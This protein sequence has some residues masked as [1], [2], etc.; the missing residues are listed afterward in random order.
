MSMNTLRWGITQSRKLSSLLEIYRL[1]PND[2]TDDEWLKEGNYYSYKNL[3]EDSGDLQIE[4]VPA[5]NFNGTNT[6][7]SV[8]SGHGL[9]NANFT[10]EC[11]ILPYTWDTDEAAITIAQSRADTSNGFSF[12][13]LA[14]DDDSD[15]LSWTWGATAS[16]VWKTGLLPPLGVWSH[17][18]ITRD[19]SSRKV[20]FNGKLFNSTADEGEVPT[21][22]VAFNL[23]KDTISSRYFFNGRIADV[24]VWNTTRT[25]QQIRDNMYETLTGSETGLLS[26]WKMTEGTGSTLTDDAGSNDMTIY[27]GNWTDPYYG[28]LCIE[29]PNRISNALDLDDIKSVSTSKID[30]DI[31]N[32]VDFKSCLNFDGTDDKINLPTDAYNFAGDSSFTVEAWVNLDKLGAVQTVMA[33]DLYTSNKRCWRAQFE[34]TGKLRM[35]TFQ[36]GTISPVTE[37]TSTTSIPV[38]TWVHCAWVKDSTTAKLYINGQLDKSGTIGNIYSTSGVK[39]TIGALDGPAQ[40]VDGKIDEVRIWNDVRT[41]TEIEDNMFTELTGSESGLVGYWKFNEDTGSTAEDSSGEHD[42]QSGKVDKSIYISRKG[43]AVSGTAA[44]DNLANYTMMGWVKANTY[45]SNQNIFNKWNTSENKRSVRLFISAQNQ[46]TLQVST[47]GTYESDNKIDISE[48]MENTWVHVAV[49]FDGTNHKVYIN[50][51]YEDQLTSSKYTS[52]DPFYIGVYHGGLVRELFDGELDEIMLFKRAL[53]AQEIEDIY[54]AQNAGG[55][56]G[57]MDDT[58]LLAFLHFED[59]ITDSSPEENATAFVSPTGT[60]SGATWDVGPKVEAKVLTAVTDDGDDPPTE[61]VLEFD[62]SSVDCGNDSSL[63]LTGNLTVS[64]W[65]KPFYIENYPTILQ[66]ADGYSEGYSLY[67]KDEVGKM[68]GAS[69]NDSG[70]YY[71]AQFGN[72]TPN[73]WV[74]VAWTWDGSEIR[75]YVDGQPATINFTNTYSVAHA[76]DGVKL[77]TGDLA[78]A[79]YYGQMR[80]VRVYGRQLS[81]SEIEDLYDGTAVSSTNLVG[82]WM[83]DEGTGTTITDSSSEGNDGTAT[84]TNWVTTTEFSFTEATKNS[85]IPEISESEDLTGKYLWVKKTLLTTTNTTP[86]IS[87]IETEIKGG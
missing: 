35:A 32:N 46:L 47:D 1:E 28:R 74:H 56:D 24:R 52:S 67:L 62:A 43:I 40:F 8:G 79:D 7:A 75:G 44:S 20:Y 45:S 48:T 68:F 64:A 54:T 33:H 78:N 57:D 6:Y 85:S 23:S 5:L 71:V 31:S 51:A 39:S 16:N 60:I 66:S 59:N 55:Q 42:Y 61:S 69:Y 36:D 25:E 38:R 2:L 14:A 18:A 13:K 34:A 9:L 65:L 11:W 17:I 41:Q 80:D 19:A 73:E 82:H 86:T 87:S 50:G 3:D 72:F 29:K 15:G 83:C 63:N 49:A 4:N 21:A 12:F 10:F 77:G 30:W 58:G 26:Y 37:V 27:N 70:T 84:D 81:D 53:S 76:F 22:N